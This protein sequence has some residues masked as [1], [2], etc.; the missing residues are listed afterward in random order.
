[1]AKGGFGEVHKA[2]WIGYD[3]YRKDVVLKRLYNPS[4][5][6]LNILKEVNKKFN[7]DIDLKIP[8][9]RKFKG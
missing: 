7:V 5:N 1:M 2:E 6:I 3:D 8:Y 9:R 4:D